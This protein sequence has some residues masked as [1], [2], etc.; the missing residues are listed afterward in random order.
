MRESIDGGNTFQEVAFLSAT[1]L[2]QYNFLRITTAV[3]SLTYQVIGITTEGTLVP[4]NQATVFREESMG[5]TVMNAYPSPARDQVHISVNRSGRAAIE[6]ITPQG[7]I[8]HRQ[9]A[10][11]QGNPVPVELRAINDGVYLIRVR[12]HDGEVVQQRVVRV[13]D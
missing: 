10:D 8:N 2:D 4:S 9:D 12:F 13:R 7:Q 1:G 6:V 11:F 5:L 3:G